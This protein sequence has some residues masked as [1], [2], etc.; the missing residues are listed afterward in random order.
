VLLQLV[1][2]SSLFEHDYLAGL[3]KHIWSRYRDLSCKLRFRRSTITI[4]ISLIKFT[5]IHGISMK[6]C[7]E[8]KEAFLSSWKGLKMRDWYFFYTRLDG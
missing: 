6:R 8:Q 5:V 4:T 1:S 3:G 2:V 7:R